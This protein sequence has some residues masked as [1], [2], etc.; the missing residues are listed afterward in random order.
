MTVLSEPGTPAPG[1]AVGATTGAAWLERY[2]G[3]VMNTFGTPSRVLVRGEGAHVWDA[4]GKEYVDLLAGI[5]E[6]GRAH[7]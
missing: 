3:A 5:A 1:P 7:V 4:D 2:T 6:I